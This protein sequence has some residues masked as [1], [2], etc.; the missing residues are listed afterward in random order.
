VRSPTVVHVNHLALVVNAAARN[1]RLEV[2][3]LESLPIR[4]K[5]L[6]ERSAAAWFARAVRIY[7]LLRAVLGC[8]HLP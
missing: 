6:G 4:K 3:L 5:V 2:Q 7:A 1:Y 8:D